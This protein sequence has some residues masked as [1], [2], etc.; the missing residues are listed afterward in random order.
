M[1]IAAR[2]TLEDFLK[3]PQ[4]DERRLELID[5][6]VC[7]KPMPTFEHGTLAGELYAA[8]RTFGYASVE[9]RAIIPAVQRFDASSPVPGV[10]FYR[11]R[12]PPPGDWMRFPPHVSIEIVSPG[13]SRLELRAKIELYLAFGVESAWIVDPERR[14][15]EVHEA[16]TRRVFADGET[17]TTPAVP[18]LSLDVSALFDSAAD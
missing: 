11:D 8:L 13:Q 16:G 3:D 12:R 4:I 2:V 10:S 7:E 18:G 5:G 1:A 15:I 17:L 9:A 6:E 14:A